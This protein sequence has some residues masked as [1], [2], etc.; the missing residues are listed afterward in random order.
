MQRTN[1]S[2]RRRHKNMPETNTTKPNNNP[3]NTKQ[4]SWI[5]RIQLKRLEKQGKKRIQKLAKKTELIGNERTQTEQ[6][7]LKLSEIFLIKN[8]EEQEINQ[9]NIK[10]L[11]EKELT[12]LLTEALKELEKEI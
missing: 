6:I 12:E 1:N 7:I 2:L 10:Q 11:T 4:L 5:Q 3:I 9:Q 8:E